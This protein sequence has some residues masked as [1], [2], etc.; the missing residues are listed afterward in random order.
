ML[1]FCELCVL[2]ETHVPLEKKHHEH[3]CQLVSR[4]N[5]L[6]RVIR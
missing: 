4:R 2:R 3:F 6:Q 1:E 5:P